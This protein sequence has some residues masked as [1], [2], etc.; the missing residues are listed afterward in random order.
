[1]PSHASHDSSSVDV[2]DTRDRVADI[3]KAR[4]ELSETYGLAENCDV[5][6]GLADEL[7]A[8]Y[9][10]E[11]CYAVTTKWVHNTRSDPIST[12]HP[13]HVDP[14][15]ILSRVPAHP[16]ALPLHLACMHHIHRLR[17]S[18][19]MLAHDLVDQDPAAATTWYAVGLWYFSGK[20]WA[21]ARRY[22]R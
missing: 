22:F 12:S 1:L 11:D 2:Q 3:I 16:A 18:L 5:L 15:R 20:R 10:W 21:E 19:F 8:K 7:Y 4:E 9:K 14:H 6:V 13:A 17:S